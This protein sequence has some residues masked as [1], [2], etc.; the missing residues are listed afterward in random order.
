MYL[1]EIQRKYSMHDKTPDSIKQYNFISKLGRGAF[2]TVYK[3]FNRHDRHAYAAKII[4]KKRISSESDRTFFQ[5]EINALAFIRHPGIVQLHDFFEDDLNYY[6]ITDFCSG[7]ELYNYIIEK[8][9]IDEPTAA[10]IFKQ[11]VVAVSYCH[12]YGIA[13]RDLKP[14]N[15]LIDKFPLVRVSDFGLCGYLRE[16]QMMKTFCGSP[17]YCAPECLNQCSYDGK[18]SDVWSLGVI[19]FA[20]VTGEHPWKLG[21]TPNMIKQISSGQYTCPD[22]LSKDCK[23]LISRMLTVDASLRISTDDILSHHWFNIEIQSKVIKSNYGNQLVNR[24]LPPKPLIKL[25]DLTQASAIGDIPISHNG[26]ITPFEE[27]DGYNFPSI[28]VR[29]N[30]FGSLLKKNANTSSLKEDKMHLKIA[31]MSLSSS[32]QRSANLLVVKK[33]V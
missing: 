5:R 33:P 12:S 17:C 10:V 2:S 29:S 4:S 15:I 13:H 28:A 21:N 23:D 6:L 11:I 27:S 22:H 26:I 32:R 8:K 7:G 14:E 24:P 31:G 3:V 19:L 16:N 30:S 1:S 20:M 18:K 25:E 9:Q